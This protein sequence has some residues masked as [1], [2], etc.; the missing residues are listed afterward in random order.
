MYPIF[1]RDELHQERAKLKNQQGIAT[2]K[3]SAQVRK[4]MECYYRSNYY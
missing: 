3:I 4:R 2:N 1:Y